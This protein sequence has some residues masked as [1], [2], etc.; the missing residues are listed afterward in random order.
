MASFNPNT[1]LKNL[2][3]SIKNRRGPKHK[4][5]KK[6]GEMTT[7]EKT[8]LVLNTFKGKELQFNINA[9]QTDEERRKRATALIQAFVKRW[10]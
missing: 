3:R 6:L 10:I 7:I 2:E 4:S 9:S 5:P 8:S 1:I